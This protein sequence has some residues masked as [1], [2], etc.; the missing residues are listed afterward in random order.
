MDDTPAPASEQLDPLRLGVLL[1]LVSLAIGG[2]FGLIAV[3]DADNP[4]SAFGQGMGAMVLIFTGGATLAVALAA[5]ARGIVPPVGVAAVVA[6]GATI[7]LSAIAIWQSPESDA[8]GK[9]IACLGVWSFVLLLGL[10]LGLAVT[11]AQGLARVLFLVTLGATVVVGAVATW[12]IATTG[13]EVALDDPVASLGVEGDGG[14]RVIGAGL[15]VLSACWFGALA[16][17]RADRA[18]GV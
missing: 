16:A 4:Y 15:V 14:L 9:L 3:L 12:L 11:G 17:H 7:D 10:G 8:Y 2:V 6:A 13:T 1:T 18:T 5:L